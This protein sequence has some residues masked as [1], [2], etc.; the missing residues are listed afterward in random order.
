M[1]NSSFCILAFIFI[2]VLITVTLFFIENIKQKE[3]VAV[4]ALE[5]LKMQQ[6]E[7]VNALAKIQ[8]QQDFK[9]KI[10]Q[11]SATLFGFKAITEFKKHNLEGAKEF[12]EISLLLDRKN[13]KANSTIAKIKMTEGKFEEAL[14]I[15]LENPDP[16]EQSD[17]TD[18][19]RA[20]IDHKSKL[21]ID[22]NSMYGLLKKHIKPNRTPFYNLILQ[23]RINLPGLSKLIMTLINLISALN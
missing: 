14:N 3:T 20:V 10:G 11:E 1:R 8:E 13:L 18:F 16:V 5:K 23:S 12:A 2:S 21:G 6:D 15:M 22:L 4:E 7:T 19:C 9:E 17:L